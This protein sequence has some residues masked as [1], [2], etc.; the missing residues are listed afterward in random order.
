MKI[1]YL[2]RGNSVHD[3][4]L[5][6]KMIDRG[7]MVYFISYFPSERVNVRG[8]EN[9]HYD[10][11]SMHRFPKFILLQTALHL[12]KL[13]KRIRPDVLHTGWV[14]DHGFIGALSGFHPILSMP[15]G[16]DVLI[17]PYD[18]VW[19]MWITRFTLRRAGMIACDA[20][21]VKEQ[22]IKLSGCSSNKIVV[23]PVGID[24]RTFHPESSSEVRKRLGW[25]DKKV[26]ICTRNF[27]IKVHGVEYF[28][29]AIPP[30]LERYPDVRVILVGSG[31]LEHEYRKLVSKLG[32]DDV[33][34]FA[35]WLNEIQMAEHLNAADIYVSTS[36]SDGTSCSL[37][38]AMAC[39]LPV[40]VTD[41]PSYFEWIEDGGNGYI[42]PRKDIEQLVKAIITL[43][44]NPGLQREMGSRNL[45][46]ANDR[47]DWDKNFGILEG[48]YKKLAAAY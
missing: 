35:G 17:R 45:Q 39:G 36:L 11:T 40:V 4:R 16:S 14:Q 18:S 13:L 3:Q 23:F 27:D 26:L 33:V 48:I 6:E 41:V 5:L 21:S 31:P 2:S 46:I 1:A 10:Y 43:L 19:A 12:R 7:H 8:V 28:I 37:L 47:A 20:W 15:W 32:L 9:Y 42:V 24:L 30:V 25:D 29:L 34:H 38:E 44:E 22:V